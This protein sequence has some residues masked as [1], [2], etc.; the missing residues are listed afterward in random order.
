MAYSYKHP[1][2]IFMAMGALNAALKNANGCS[3]AWD[4]LTYTAK[5]EAHLTKRGLR[6]FGDATIQ[7]QLTNGAHI[8]K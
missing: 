5:T 8:Q 6:C 2:A 4:F 1:E 3:L 7:Q